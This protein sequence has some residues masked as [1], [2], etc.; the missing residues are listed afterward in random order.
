MEPEGGKVNDMAD[1]I[2]AALWIVANLT[3]LYVQV[4]VLAWFGLY[5]RFDWKRTPAG[6]DIFLLVA[7]LTALIVQSVAGVF[8]NPLGRQPWWEAPAELP[9]WYGALRYAVSLFLA[10]AVS[11]IVWSLIQRLR[12]R[13]PW[14]FEI[15]PREPKADTGP[16]RRVR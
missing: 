14:A 12:G 11:R 6:Q 5:L 16:T 10:V 4:G 9:L 3:V 1:N 15:V 2:G 13:Q 8:V 7:S